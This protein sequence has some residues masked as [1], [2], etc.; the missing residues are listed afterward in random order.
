MSKR[1]VPRHVLLIFAWCV[2]LAQ[3]IYHWNI[4]SGC[5][6]IWATL[7]I[8]QYQLYQ[9]YLFRILV[10]ILILRVGYD[11][12]QMH[13]Q[14]HFHFK[15]NE[16][17][18]IDT[19][20][21]DL[22]VKQDRVTGQAILHSKNRPPVKTRIN[23]PLDLI[24]QDIERIQ[25]VS[26]R[27]QVEGDIKG[28]EGARNFHVFDYQQFARMQHMY[29]EMNIHKVLSAYDS[30]TLSSLY[31]NCRATLLKP[32]RKFEDHPWI[33]IQNIIFLNLSSLPYQ[34]LKEDFSRWGIAHFFAISGFHI[35]LMIK[36][37]D[38][39][40]RK[41]GV[42]I[43]QI[44]WMIFSILV[45]YGC[46]IGWPIGAIRA[47]GCYGLKFLL[48]KCSWKLTSL[49]QVAL[50]GL[51][52]MMIQP[53]LVCQ[54]G[55]ILSFW[56]TI[57]IKF[58]QPYHQSNSWEMNALCLLLS[59]PITVNLSHQWHPGIF[60]GLFVFAMIFEKIMLPSM[61]CTLI[62]NLCLPQWLSWFLE[63]IEN[64]HPKLWHHG[65]V[66]KLLTHGFINMHIQP[67]IMGWMV[68][69]I[70]GILHLYHRKHRNIFWLA[71]LIIHLFMMQIPYLPRLT[72]S[73]TMIDVQ[74]G[75]AMLVQP[76]WSS[77][78]WLIDTGGKLSWTE[79][80]ETT[81]DEN[82][83][84]RTI[85]PALRGLNVDTI[86]YL[87]ITHVDADHFG[88]I[89][90]VLKNF[91]VKHIIITPQTQ[92]S[93][94]FQAILPDI[95]KN[96]QVQV[97]ATSQRLS[98]QNTLQ[99]YNPAREN[100][101]S[102]RNAGSL[103][104]YIN[105]GNI[106]VL[107]MADLP[108]EFEQDIEGVLPWRSTQILKVGHHGS[109]S[110]TSP[111]LLSQIKATQAWISVGKNN[112]YGHPHPSVIQRLRQSDLRIWTTAENGAVQVS[113]DIFGNIWMT[114]ALE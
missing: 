47:I 95:R 75:D 85:V 58:F 89:G 1:D 86:D 83:A 36:T 40:L 45:M 92:A 96:T 50:V 28:I 31:H 93:S 18:W 4:F 8:A 9:T 111:W 66:E 99:I 63:Q 62:C 25:Q 69:S 32:F 49:D 34:A 41:I 107:N 88:N 24:T 26:L 21:L 100:H 10:I 19:Q 114:T 27:L 84:D 65:W 76:S 54:I 6:L 37:L 87:V 51:V 70:I 112:H 38:K 108:S 48:N 90:K 60:V 57:I 39:L 7:K 103:V 110:S 81:I 61:L 29:Y 79:D 44:P 101:P 102:D 17:V 35:S 23:L 98:I 71:W 82:F 53:T 55:Y 3:V 109:D 16:I 46:L 72:G 2:F 68:C 64:I 67:W 11:S 33:S 13:A 105:L 14:D 20:P 59:W 113:Q 97:L 91:Q 106:S 22:S 104:T 77:E 15:S 12:I 30:P 80:S 74:Q 56:M 52:M 5:L 42:Y 73:I 78:N 94:E 43:D